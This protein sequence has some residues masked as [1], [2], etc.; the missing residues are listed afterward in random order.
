MS[1]RVNIVH[2]S[3]RDRLKNKFELD[4]DDYL[5]ALIQF[6]KL[7]KPAPKTSRIGSL[8]KFLSYSIQ[9]YTKGCVLYSVNLL[10][11]KYNSGMVSKS[12]LTLPYLEG[13]IKK[14][15]ANIDIILNSLKKTCDI[16]GA[17]IST[18][19]QSNLSD[20]ENKCQVCGNFLANY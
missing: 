4:D 15:Y 17:E 10:M 11:K 13:I 1:Y 12:T 6:H 20:Q 9:K 5:K 2:L 7:Y 8:E 19:V 18:N 16:C 14:N 3:P